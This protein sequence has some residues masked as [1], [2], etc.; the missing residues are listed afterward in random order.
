MLKNI[1]EDNGDIKSL[2]SLIELQSKNG[3]S[4]DLEKY[5]ELINLN[6]D[7]FNF[8]KAAQY[9]KQ[10]YPLMTNVQK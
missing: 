5:I 7:S 10:A 2:A 3:V 4:L 1:Y 9:T 8:K 6:E